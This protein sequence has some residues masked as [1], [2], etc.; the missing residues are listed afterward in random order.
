M[1]IEIHLKRELFL[2][3]RFH[4][5][6]IYSRGTTLKLIHKE[7]IIIFPISFLHSSFIFL[8]NIIVKKYNSFSYNKL[9]LVTNIYTE[10]LCLV[11]F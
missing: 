6:D 10:A 3:Y 2:W 8:D 1:Y 4:S 9:K 5:K 11:N 7:R